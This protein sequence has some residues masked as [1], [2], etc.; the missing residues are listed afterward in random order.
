MTHDTRQA[1][2]PCAARSAPLRGIC[3]GRIAAPCCRVQKSRMVGTSVRQ[4]TCASAH[5]RAFIQD[6][7]PHVRTCASAH[8]MNRGGGSS[9][10]KRG[11]LRKR[12][13]V[14]SPPGGGGHI[15]PHPPAMGPIS[16]FRVLSHLRTSVF[17]QKPSDKRFWTKDGR[18]AALFQKIF[19][20]RQMFFR[21]PTNYCLDK[22]T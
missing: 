20:E 5:Q 9:V 11:V 19:G 17:G 3:A 2:C 8:R 13:R 18:Q 22:Q 1:T 4:H 10:R 7:Q 15:P 16:L 21:Q 6:H 12:H 14:Q